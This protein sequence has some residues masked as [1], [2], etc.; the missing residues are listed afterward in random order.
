VDL[1]NSPPYQHLDHLNKHNDQQQQPMHHPKDLSDF[2]EG[3]SDDDP[4]VDADGN[5][6]SSDDR[7]KH[8]PPGPAQLRQRPASGSSVNGGGGSSSSPGTR[9]RVTPFVVDG[10]SSVMMTQICYEETPKGDAK[11]SDSSS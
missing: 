10:Q 2:S 9:C 6:T 8:L 11:S 1:R 5:V 4:D 7:G 3:K